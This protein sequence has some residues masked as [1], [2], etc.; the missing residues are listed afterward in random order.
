MLPHAPK[1]KSAVFDMVINIMYYFYTNA[2]NCKN[3]SHGYRRPV[4]ATLNTD[5][6]GGNIRHR[7]HH[8]HQHFGR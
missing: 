3:F 5:C 2:V 7:Q 1:P 4:G 6:F 8:F